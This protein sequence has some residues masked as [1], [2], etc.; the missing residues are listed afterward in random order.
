LADPAF[1][2]ERRHPRGVFGGSA[3]GIGRV[4]GIEIAIDHSWVFIFLLITLSLAARFGSEHQDWSAVERWSA[5]LLASP[6]FFASILLHEL[7]HCLVAK[8]LG[9]TVRSITLFVFG[10]V[11]K[12]ESEPKRPRDEVV[13]A[14]AGPTVSVAL[15]LGFLGLVEL[16][17]A[18]SE[19]AGVLW[20]AFGWLGSI[21]LV[22]AAFNAVPGFPLD[23]GRVLRGIIWATTG[24][25]ERATTVAAALGSGV[26]FALIALGIVSALFAGQWIGGLWLVF[27]G[28]FL[29]S[30]ARATAGHAVLERALNRLRVETSMASLEGA[31]LSGHETVEEVASGPV[32]HRGLRTL[33]VVG[34]SGAL[35]GLVTLRELARV[36]ASQ[37]P[38]KTVHEIMVPVEQLSVLDP[39]ESL[40]V[41]FK[42]MAESGVNQLPVVDR[43][44]L[45]GVVTR[46][47]LVALVQAH[48]TLGRAPVR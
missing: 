47:Q 39:R 24:S 16:L 18:E 12:L 3:W 23:G 42:R 48:L 43:G 8:R 32:L 7:G 11:A 26:A 19:P 30:A 34:A 2:G 29:F 31:C 17:P 9:I 13:I 27:I 15:G 28:W 36:P 41:A 35:R 46:E 45:L 4:A 44:R 20:T 38:F 14:L 40:W 6:L 37:R 33:F 10:G 25:F 5:A 21:N 22:L 1:D